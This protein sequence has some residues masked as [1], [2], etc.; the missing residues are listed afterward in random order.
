MLSVGL[1]FPVLWDLV[2]SSVQEV[3]RDWSTE[4]QLACLL[5]A[6]ELLE[7]G[8]EHTTPQNV[9]VQITLSRSPPWDIYREALHFQAYA[10]VHNLCTIL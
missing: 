10:Y 3:T 5:G 2:L 6:L 8:R 4:T 7:V 9:C 1:H